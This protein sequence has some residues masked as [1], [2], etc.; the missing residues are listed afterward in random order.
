VWRPA[1]RP[2]RPTEPNI[3]VLGLIGSLIGLG[4]AVGLIFAFDAMRFTYKTI[5]ELERGLQ[6]PVLGGI[7][8]VETHVERSQTRRGR[9]VVSTVALLFVFL[10]VAVVTL[11]YVAPARLPTWA[12]DVLDLVLGSDG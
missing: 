10:I 7:S 6:V 8:H 9:A 4:V 12:R 1:T 3:F 2:P 5:D 11:Y